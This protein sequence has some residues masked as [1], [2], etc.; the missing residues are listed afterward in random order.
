MSLAH[1]GPLDFRVLPLYLQECISLAPCRIQD[2]LTASHAA[3]FDCYLF[4]SCPF[5]SV[6]LVACV[7][8]CTRKEDRCYY[9][10]DDGTACIEACV[11]SRLGAPDFWPGDAVRLEGKLGNGW[12]NERKVDVARISAFTLLFVPG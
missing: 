11:P 9:L 6:Q 5:K 1:L 3:K 12:Q 8:G 4:G 10:L 2:A 7:V